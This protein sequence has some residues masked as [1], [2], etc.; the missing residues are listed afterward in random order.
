MGQTRNNAKKTQTRDNAKKT[1][2]RDNGTSARN[3][4]QPDETPDQN[5]EPVLE[6]YEDASALKASV[7][8]KINGG[9]APPSVQND[10]QVSS[11][12][13]AEVIN[14]INGRNLVAENVMY[15]GLAALA[16]YASYKA[17][18]YLKKKYQY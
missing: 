2:T 15:F 9:N 18:Q 13:K 10:D 11:A 5:S 8:S 4:G 14:K 6:K 17:Y 16:V 7:I 12:L 1:Q 3:A